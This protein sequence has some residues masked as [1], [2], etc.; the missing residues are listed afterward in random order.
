MTQQKQLI[1]QETFEACNNAIDDFIGH[2]SDLE[3]IDLFCDAYDLRDL[4]GQI[5]QYVQRLRQKH[6]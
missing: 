1:L 6:R 5:E 3:S 2:A 4:A